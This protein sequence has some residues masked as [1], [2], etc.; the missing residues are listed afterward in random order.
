[1]FAVRAAD[2][3]SKC[4]QQSQKQIRSQ[5]LEFQFAKEPKTIY[6]KKTEVKKTFHD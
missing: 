3:R 2:S 4:H 6:G 5:K 1:M